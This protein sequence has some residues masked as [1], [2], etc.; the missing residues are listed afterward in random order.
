MQAA[1]AVG[2]G[3]RVASRNYPAIA[4]N[5]LIQR[6]AL[7]SRGAVRTVTLKPVSPSAASD[8][9]NSQRIKRPSSPHFTIYQPQITW[10]GSIANRATGG[11]LS[12]LLY[13]F[14]IA[15]LA[16]P[17]VGIPVDS[18]H[19]VELVHSLPEW[20]KVSFKT[21]LAA[22]FAYHAWNGVRHL[23]WDSVKLMTVKQVTRSGYAVLAATA[24]STVYLVMM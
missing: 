9:L 10:L 14:S 24:F 4:R 1:R 23:A 13:A 11:A 16:G 12:G 21:L 20:A 22:P 2:F 17:V 18:A 6:S 19:I 7:S 8:V 15:Y 5:A 3:V